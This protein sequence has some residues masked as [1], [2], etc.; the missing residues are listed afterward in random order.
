MNLVTALT[1]ARRCAVLLLAGCILALSSTTA[2]AAESTDMGNLPSGIHPYMSMGTTGE[3][4]VIALRVSFPAEA[5]GTTHVFKEGDTLEALQALIGKQLGESVDTLAVGDP[6]AAPYDSLHAFYQRSSYG[7]LDISGASYD[8]T[9][10]HPRSHYTNINALVFEALTALDSTIDF[11]AFDGNGDKLIDA[12]YLHFAGDSTGWNTLWWSNEAFYKGEPISVDGMSAGSIVTLHQPSNGAD[13]AQTIIHETGH[14]LGLPDYYSYNTALATGDPS[15]RTG[16]LTFD[17]MNTNYGD[18][19]AYSKWLLGWIDE[20]KITRIVAN[21]NGITIKEGTAAARTIAPDAQGNSAVETALSLISSDNLAECGGFIAVSNKETLLEENGL[22]SSFY[23]LEY[24]GYAGNNAVT[25]YEKWVDQTPIPSGFRVFR[26]QAGLTEAGNFAH[27]NAHSDVHD[28]FIELVDADAGL[29]HMAFIGIV[30]SIHEGGYGCMLGEGGTITPDGYPSTNFFEN[31]NTGFTGLSFEATEAGS[32]QGSVI[33]SFSNELKPNLDPND[34]TITP[35][36][37]RGVLNIDTVELVSSSK[38]TRAQGIT[39]PY[40]VAGGKKATVYVNNITDKTI[41]ISYAI[42]PESFVP[43]KTCEIVFPAGYFIIGQTEEKTVFSNEMRVS[44]P[45]GELVTFESVG[46]YAGHETM[47]EPISTPVTCSDLVTRFVQII[48]GV[49]YLCE[50]NGNDPTKVVKRALAG[51][52]PFN[53]EVGAYAV[54]AHIARGPSGPALIAVFGELGS[55]G[56][57]F[58][59]TRQ[60]A[61]W[62]DLASASAYADAVLGVTT[63]EKAS[64]SGDSLL[65]ANYEA[66]PGTSERFYVFRSFTV[67]A[68]GSVASHKVMTEG[69]KSVLEVGGMAAGLQSKLVGVCG[70]EDTCTLYGVEDMLQAMEGV[71]E[72]GFID[73]ASVTP[74]I[75]L[76]DPSCDEIV[77]ASESDSGFVAVAFDKPESVGS[78]DLEATVNG[79]L[80]LLETSAEDSPLFDEDGSTTVR[81]V[82]FDSSG[83]V[84]SSFPFAK[85]STNDVTYESILMGNFGT[86]AVVTSVGYSALRTLFF[87]DGVTAAPTT[88]SDSSDSIGGAWLKTGAWIEMNW[89]NSFREASVSS[90]AGE[91]KGSPNTSGTFAENATGSVGE[92]DLALSA[93]G[94]SV[95]YLITEILDGGFGGV[96]GGIGRPDAGDKDEPSENDSTDGGTEGEVIAPT[97]D[98]SGMLVAIFA[99]TALISL[100]AL[101]T[102]RVAL[103]RA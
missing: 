83:A 81:L 101:A 18:H 2:L 21:E 54:E 87:A 23:L 93:A 70:Y 3:A 100:V 17:M 44:L 32:S 36:A 42:S 88:L 29:Q 27:D 62:I 24:T 95:H 35:A 102:R 26:I 76:R 50:I 84:V 5:N 65:L 96:I 40:V 25:Y 80:A 63:I 69:V 67:E 45:I 41:T 13:G 38:L 103:T 46:D 92:D 7:K 48:E 14:V 1:S 28:Q 53:A 4:N 57:G 55:S 99:G 58:T 72:G 61:Y 75:K 82:S 34:L 47:R 71:A 33:I 86:P 6:V 77:A 52:G 51:V 94:Y 20:S 79:T 19:N 91:V 12:V 10:L 89:S 90:N 56:A 43:G 97:G 60:H 73:L 31:I 85:H 74:T 37:K 9:A 8:Y 30:D 49:P 16:I 22:F 68:D 59:G 39:S 64:V 15:K 66:A 98:P 11:N 78:P